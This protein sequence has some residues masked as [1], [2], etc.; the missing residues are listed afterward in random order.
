MAPF[1]SLVTVSYLH[2]IVVCEMF[3]VEE[4]CDLENWVRGFS[5]SSKMTPFDRPYTPYYWSAIVSIPLSCT[6]SM[7]NNIMT[8]K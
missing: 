3:S 1:E 6:I 7:L 8:L 5:R 4:W 2:F